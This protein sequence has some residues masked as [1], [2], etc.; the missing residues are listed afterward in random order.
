MSAATADIGDWQ[1]RLTGYWRNQSLVSQFTIA[2]GVVFL[3]AMLFCGLLISNFVRSNL[4]HQRA[5]AT[6]LFIDS[7]V[8]PELQN[9][10]TERELRPENRAN[11]DFLMREEEFGQRIPFL[12]VWL[13][14]GT[15]A[16]SNSD[17]LI[18]QKFKLPKAA[19][20]AFDGDLVSTFAD[21]AAGEHVVRR[22][23]STFSEIYSPVRK[24]GSAEIIAV[25][26]IHESVDRVAAALRDVTFLSWMT[27][28]VTGLAVAACL[29][30]IVKGGSETIL[31]QK[32]ALS[33]RLSEAQELARQYQEIKD[34]AQRASRTVT[35]MNDH[36]MRSVGADLHDGP[37]QLISFATLKVEMA[38]RAGDVDGRQRELG[39][40]ETN[41]IGALDNIRDI[42]RGLSLPAIEDLDLYAVVDQAVEQHRRRTGM[43]PPVRKF[44]LR[45]VRAPGTVSACVY[46]FIQEG[47]NNAY[48]HAEPDSAVV[49]AELVDG[50]LTVRVVSRNASARQAVQHAAGHD[51]RGIRYGLGLKGLNARVLSLGA[52]FSFVLGA[53]EACLSMAINLE[54]FAKDA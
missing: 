48:W 31:F 40:I 52:D 17:E 34:Q 7:V 47:L 9:L 54:E 38:R 1:S 45:G 19:V 27:V 13:P 11:L 36:M 20:D 8:S 32:R 37:A 41:L 16:Y 5:A 26:E 14:D 44:A 23:A 29:Y 33:A 12:E 2:G 39:E 53:T 24:D 18:G 15:V 4:L 46:R 10:D 43:L 35:E 6:A 22:F 51:A 42:A 49:E 25:V 30:F 3:I 50:V 21:L 28:G